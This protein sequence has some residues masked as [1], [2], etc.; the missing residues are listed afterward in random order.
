MKRIPLLIIC[1][2]LGGCDLQQETSEKP[3]AGYAWH[4]EHQKFQFWWTSY[5]SRRDCIEHMKAEAATGSSQWYS[6]PIG[7]AY[8]SNSYWAVWWY[9]LIYPD[10]NIECIWRSIE[11]TKIKAGYG[12]LLKGYLKDRTTKGYCV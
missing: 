2:F 8:S 12:P 6:E 3:W 10:K 7:C 9:N 5:E 1:V 4:K 11:G